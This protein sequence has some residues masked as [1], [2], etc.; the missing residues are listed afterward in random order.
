LRITGKEL[1]LISS[2]NHD[3][4]V[5][6]PG[7]RIILNRCVSDYLALAFSSHC[8]LPLLARLILL[9]VPD[10]NISK[11]QPPQACLPTG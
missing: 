1:F 8:A 7:S 11:A 5:V 10:T 2:G 9:P 4:P 6:F 3:K